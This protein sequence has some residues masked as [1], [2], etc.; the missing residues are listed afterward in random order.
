MHKAEN[1]IRRTAKDRNAR[2]LS[3]GKRSHHLVQIGFH[4][5][6][7][8]VRPRNHDFPDLDLRQLHGAEDEFLFAW[9]DQAALPRL[10]NLDLQ[11]FRGMGNAVNL[12]R[13]HT[14]GLH[15]RARNTIKQINRPMK[16]VQE[17]LEGQSHQKRDALRAGKTECLRD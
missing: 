3:G 9:R 2:A 11:F 7:V 1:V 16:S 5:K 6:C 15:N 4:G 12:R 8:H 10:L 14:E 13:S 17:P